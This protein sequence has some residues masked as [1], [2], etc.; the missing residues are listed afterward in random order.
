MG[1]SSSPKG[2]PPTAEN[3][4]GKAAANFS[5]PDSN[6]VQVA[7]ADYKGK[8]VLLNFWATWCGPCKIEIPWFMEF[9]KTYKDR[10]FAVLG[11]SLDDDEWKSVRPYLAEKKMDY[12]VMVG[13][14]Q[15]SQSYGGIDSL[16]TTFIIDRDGRIAFV[17]MGLVG[18]ETYEK[19]IRNLL[20]GERSA[21][22]AD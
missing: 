4:D 5:L 16:P 19:E 2:T 13:N 10:G 6:G 22:I 17:H 14:D 7:L 9:N 3:R 18:K 12:P 1:C 15:V 20:G 11:V 21:V 8:V